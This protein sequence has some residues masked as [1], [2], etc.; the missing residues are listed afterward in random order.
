MINIKMDFGELDSNHPFWAILRL[1]VGL[2]GLTVILAYNAS[3]FDETEMK[4][5]VAFL[6]F[7]SGGEGAVKMVKRMARAAGKENGHGKG[8]GDTQTF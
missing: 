4:A 6:L 5:I 7:Q 2:I 3:H 8:S 1:A